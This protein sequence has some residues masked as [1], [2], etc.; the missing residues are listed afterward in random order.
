[1]FDGRAIGHALSGVGLLVFVAGV[2]FLLEQIRSC[3]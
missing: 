1:M 2:V 3:T